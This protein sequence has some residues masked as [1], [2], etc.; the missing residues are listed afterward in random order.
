MRAAVLA[1]LVACGKSSSDAPGTDPSLGPKEAAVAAWQKDGMEV[2]PLAKATNGPDCATTVAD[3]VDVLVCS[4][5]SPDEAK[6][7]ADGM[8]K[9]VGDTTGSSQAVGS[10]VVAA[11]DRHKAD[12][13]GRTINR[14]F[15][16][17][18]P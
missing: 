8:L 4:Y 16:V 15:K 12:V 10:L 9:W 6:R 13:N 3:K 2:A 5:P 17:L 18:R 11:A 7:A 1:L 14:L